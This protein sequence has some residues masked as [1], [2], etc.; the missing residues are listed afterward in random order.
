MLLWEQARSWILQHAV[1]SFLTGRP[2]LFSHGQTC[3][4]YV[5]HARWIIYFARS[6]SNLFMVIFIH[7]LRVYTL[8]HSCLIKV[9]SI[10]GNRRT[11]FLTRSSS[12]K[13]ALTT[14][15]YYSILRYTR[16]NLFTGKFESLWLFL[17]DDV[18]CRGLVRSCPCDR[19]FFCKHSLYVCVMIEHRHIDLWCVV[20]CVCSC[21][22]VLAGTW[23]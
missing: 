20:C 3:P 23:G 21:P 1:P 7:N 14:F 10:Y 4:I 22:G 17:V 15:I 12:S 2:F 16:P 6:K 5:K 13:E 9:Q 11:M 8:A 18:I 19:T